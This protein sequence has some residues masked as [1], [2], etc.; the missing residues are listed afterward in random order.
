M[1]SVYIHSPSQSGLGTFQV[2]RSHVGLAA[3]TLQSSSMDTQR[4][5]ILVLGESV[6]LSIFY[7]VCDR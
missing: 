6:L 3:A 2:F 1:W 7:D 4:L 5:L